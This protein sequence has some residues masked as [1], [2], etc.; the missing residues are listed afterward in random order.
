MDSRLTRGMNPA[1]AADW[2]SWYRSSRSH[3]AELSRVLESG[4]ANSRGDS[5]AATTFS[6]P[7]ALAE[8][9]HKAGYRE[10]LREAIRLLTERK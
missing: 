10:G 6:G 2:A 3:L 9:A 1:E 4:I 5:D 7:N 8:L